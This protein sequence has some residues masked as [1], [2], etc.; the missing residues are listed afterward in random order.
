MAKVNHKKY[1][2]KKCQKCKELFEGGLKVK[3]ML[4]HYCKVEIEWLDAQS[5]FG[6]A[7]YVEDLIQEKPQHSFSVG[8]LLHE[9]KD[10]IILGFMLFGEDMVKHNQLIPRGMVKKVRYLN[11]TPKKS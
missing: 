9:H 5:G 4:N 6:N 2:F 10:Y 3:D 8:Y 1:P 7:Q 11:Y